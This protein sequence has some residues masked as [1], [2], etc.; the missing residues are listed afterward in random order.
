MIDD[1]IIIDNAISSNYQEAIFDRLLTDRN[2]PWYYIPN[3]TRKTE[4]E[5]IFEND[6]FGFAHAFLDREGKCRSILN[7]FLLPVAYESCDKI[8]YEPTDFYYGR[9][10]MTVAMKNS[11]AHNMFHVDM[12]PPHLVCLYYVNDSSG[13]TLIT[14]KTMED[15]SHEEINSQ[16]D[17]EIIKTVEP[18][19]GRAVLFNGKYFHAS[20]NPIQGRRCIINFDLG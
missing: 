8:N 20:S 15:I 2:F 10:F 18:K 3:I 6:S 4:G 7:D 1:I 5:E 12:I 11:P 19:K 13:P 16:K 9:I 14:N 17:I